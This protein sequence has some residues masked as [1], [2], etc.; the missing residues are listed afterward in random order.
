MTRQ[1][2][3]RD[4]RDLRRELAELKRRIK[5]LETSP[6]MGNSSVSHG[7]FLIRDSDGSSD[8][9]VLRVGYLGQ[10]SSAD[11]RG[12]EVRRP[13]GELVLSTWSGADQ[14]RFW[15]MFDIAENRVISDDAVS[16]QGLATPY[17]GAPVFAP[18][19]T[20]KWPSTTSSTYAPAWIGMWWKQHPRLHVIVWAKSDSGTSG[21]V[22]V[23]CNGASASASIGSAENGIKEL[24]LTVP[25]GHLSWQEVEIDFRRTGG[26]GFLG[27]YPMGVYG[28]QS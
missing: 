2:T 22:Q 1:N 26:S 3:R 25:G 7:K 15:G 28:I 23:T 27:C 11:V 10:Y 17:I 21:D 13:T 9:D 8:V 14:G 4:E 19:D 16:G 6:R 12:T 18:F 24:F 20:S 5:A